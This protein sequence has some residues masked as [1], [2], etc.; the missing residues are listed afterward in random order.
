MSSKLLL[1]FF[2]GAALIYGYM[3]YKPVEITAPDSVSANSFF[4]VESNK[5]GDW[6][7]EGDVSHIQDGKKLFIL[8]GE[9]DIK[10][11]Y[12]PGLIEKTVKISSLPD[13]FTL[14]IQE[15]APSSGRSVVA[16]SLKALALGFDGDSVEDFVRLTKLNNKILID[17]DW[18]VFFENLGKYCEENMA[19]KDLQAHK[20]LWL[21]VA[22]A[23]NE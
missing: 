16:K 5:S 13:S 14:M 10:I 21:K 1:I 17:S 6:L 7:V 18:K 2:V 8:A 22:E 20:E 19:D 23:L 11:I 15:W 4:L 9:K 12:S 3:Q